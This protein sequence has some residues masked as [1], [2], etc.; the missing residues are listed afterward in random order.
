MTLSALICTYN[1]EVFIGLCLE[2]LLPFVDEVIVVDNGST[3]RTKEIIQSFNNPKI[4][5]YDYPR[6]EP[7]DMG[8]VRSFSLEKATGDWFLQVD[9][10]E[11]YPDT[12]LR[13]IR[14]T[15][16]QSPETGIISI[17]VA[18][19]N[20]AWKEGYAQKDFGHYPDRVYK[21]EVV[22]GYKGVLPRDMTYV[23]REHLLAPNKPFG[24]IGVL[25][26]DNMDDR[27]FEHPRQP[28][29]KDIFF[30]HLARTRGYNYE[31]QKWR[32]YNRN[33]N[34]GISEQ[35][36]DRLTRINQWVSGQYDIEPI[37]VPA[38]IPTST[39]V[40]P[41][42]SVVIT[43]FN[44]ARF[45]G[46]AITSVLEQTKKAYEIIV[47]D[48]HS[49]DNSREVLSHFGNQITTV[50]RDHNGGPG[51]AR[52]DGVSRTTGDY[53]IM[54]DADDRLKPE[55]I[56]TFLRE[57]GKEQITYPDMICMSTR[58]GVRDGLWQMPDYTPERMLEAQC[59][60]SVCALIERHVFNV[61]G[62]FDHRA[63]YEDWDFFLNCQE[64]Y[65]VLFRHI[66]IP[67]LEYRAHNESRS[68][69]NDAHQRE[70]YA[71][72]RRK[73]PRIKV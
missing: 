22:E 67:L 52:N 43:N 40:D 64:N 54:L 14:D 7:V 37:D 24:D 61:T 49:G 23:K 51:A 33:T 5:F 20:L 57:K 55:A 3:D 46:Q 4:K 8:K 9:A 62:G 36:V 68:N 21:K 19:K 63:M 72:L 30:Y 53:F 10:D 15:I 31:Y 27:S 60:P 35:E 70:A 69:F 48:D 25:E 13:I 28:I 1:E 11:I 59:V 44:Y 32:R 56:E 73:Y 71:N 45:V 6:V 34:P 26:Y 12:S 42:V 2:H 39:I 38:N 29:R 65:H 17:R 47:V 50:F 58:P 18:Y 16:E 66:P 41:K